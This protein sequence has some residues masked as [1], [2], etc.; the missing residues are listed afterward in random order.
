MLDDLLIPAPLEATSW[1][2]LGIDPSM[3]RTGYAA[4]VVEN[5]PVA[6]KTKAS[7][8]AI[9]SVKGN[10]AD[11]EWVRA[12]MYAEHMRGLLYQ[13]FPG[14][15]LII[16]MEF[17]TPDNTFLVQLNRIIHLEF[18]RD[19]SVIHYKPIRVLT[20]NASTMRSVHGLKMRGAKNKVENMARAYDYVG[21]EEY[22]GLDSDSC[23]GVLMAM[24]G[25]H[26]AS[27]CMGVH[28]EV[29]DNFL[30]TLCS[31]KQEIKRKGRPTQFTVT[32]GLMHRPGYWYGYE[33]RSYE[34]SIKDAT[35]PLG[36]RLAS[37]S[38]LI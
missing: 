3:S 35:I 31:G 33:P 10:A 5:D 36:K 34:V 14:R 4:M 19:P 22:P 18:F 9:G 28:D 24:I 6:G 13:D 12:K 38:Y 1:L 25:R 29:P 32:K 30:N 8:E 27:V 16:S 23:D 17:P 21:K 20:I 2:I 11:P 37:A 15:G 26:A 7:W